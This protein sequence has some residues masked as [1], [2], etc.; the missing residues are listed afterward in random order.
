[1]E[2]T[3]Y[4]SMDASRLSLVPARACGTRRGIVMSQHTCLYNISCI[5]HTTVSTLHFVGLKL[6]TGAAL[7]V[8]TTVCH[9]L[10][11]VQTKPLHFRI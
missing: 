10:Q 8:R 2:G 1:V 5:N 7:P 6:I 4:E 3:T 11:L 9:H